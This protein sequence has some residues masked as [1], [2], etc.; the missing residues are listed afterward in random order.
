MSEV[1]PLKL[2]PE[3]TDKE[4][5]LAK[6]DEYVKNMREYLEGGH[7]AGF[8]LLGYTRFTDKGDNHITT[9]CNVHVHD[10]A[11]AFWLPDAAKTRVYNRMHD[12]P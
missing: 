7:N 8:A 1:V 5:M 11:D 10:P 6:F 12:E 4:V 2:V 9:W 3:A